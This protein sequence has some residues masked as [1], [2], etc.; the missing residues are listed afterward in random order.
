MGNLAVNGCEQLRAAQVVPE[1]YRDLLVRVG[2][3]PAYFTDLPPEMQDWQ[4]K[5]CEQY[6]SA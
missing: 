4:I 3:W 5:K 1:K 6:A 2:G